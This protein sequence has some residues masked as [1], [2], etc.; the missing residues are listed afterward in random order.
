MGERGIFVR[1]GY[2]GDAWPGSAEVENPS[3]TRR[4]NSQHK[5][6]TYRAISIILRSLSIRVNCRSSGFVN[7]LEIFCG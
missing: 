3:N 6:L 4:K 1:F 7:C 2:V 5:F